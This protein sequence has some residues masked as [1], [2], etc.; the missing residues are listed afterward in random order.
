MLDRLPKERVV[1]LAREDLIGEF[2]LTDLASVEID[3]VDVCHRSSL[4]MP[5]IDAAG[6]NCI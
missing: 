2:E 4:F 3:Y 6:Q 1:D 5:A